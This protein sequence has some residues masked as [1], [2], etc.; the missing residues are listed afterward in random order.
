M[1]QRRQLLEHRPRRLALPVRL[2]ASSSVSFEKIVDPLKVERSRSACASGGTGPPC[3][4]TATRVRSSAAGTTR[5]ITVIRRVERCTRQARPDGQA[6]LDDPQALRSAEARA[7]AKRAGRLRQAGHDPRTADDQPGRAPRGTTG[8]NPDRTRE[9]V[10]RVYAG[11]CRRER[12]GRELGRDAPGGTLRVI[13]AVYGGAATVLPAAGQATVEVPAR[14]ALSITPR[15]TLWSG[16]I[17]IR[18]HLDGGYVPPD[19]VALRLLVRY[20]GSRLGSPLLALRTNP[21]ARSRSSGPTTPGA[22][23]RP[24]RSG[25]RR[26]RPR[27]TTHSPRATAERSP[28]RSAAK[29][30]PLL[31]LRLVSNMNRTLE[32]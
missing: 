11:R 21:P 3:C 31:P 7:Q 13:R 24:T 19:G 5:T 16:V 23:S 32:R 26:P 29:P 27:A 20:P 17:T 1:R 6:A 14:I 10:G 22:G 15:E 28:S 25:S 9:R 4:A 8:P 2:A 12:A 18:G 30:P